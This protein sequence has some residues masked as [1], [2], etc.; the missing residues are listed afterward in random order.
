MRNWIVLL[1]SL[2]FAAA[3]GYALLTLAPTPASDAKGDRAASRPAEKRAPA[4]T[5]DDKATAPRDHIGDASRAALREV[6]READE[7][8]D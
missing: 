4:R 2:G 5:V 8:G 7:E 1:A 3:V 6:L